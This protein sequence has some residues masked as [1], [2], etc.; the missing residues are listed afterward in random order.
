MTKKNND[1]TKPI[2]TV[3]DLTRRINESYD[4]KRK[5]AV[6]LQE[7]QRARL[8]IAIQEEKDL[9][10]KLK[11]AQGITAKME[12]DYSAIEIK[13]EAEKKERIE[14][15]SIREK[16][17]LSGKV[18]L[19][20]FTQKG[21]SEKQITEKAIKEAIAELGNSLKAVRTK[22]IEILE[23]QRSLYGC[24]NRIKNLILQP[25]LIL[26]RIHKDM[27]EVSDIEIGEFLADI[28]GARDSLKQAEHFIFL[29]QGKSLGSGHRWDRLTVKEA[30]QI[31]FDP[32]LPFE[33]IPKLKAELE[34]FKLAEFI[35][36][37]FW[38]R[39]K[40]IDVNPTFKKTKLSRG[41]K[42]IKTSDLKERL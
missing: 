8:D 28:Y 26:Q 35:S 41:D 13:L 27:L 34:K 24:Q 16:D 36:V 18:T 31:V 5:E 11:I 39:A 23:I 32:I 33:L 1:D 22:R 4:R 30:K 19:R 7:E 38:L 17:V 2:Q 40:D 42:T 12:Q 29:T 25:A 20:E 15:E 9:T 3:P 21:T 14:K 37:I 10:E 6:L